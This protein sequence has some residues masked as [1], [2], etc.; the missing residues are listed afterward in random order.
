MTIWNKVYS[1]GLIKKSLDAMSDFY[2]VMAEDWYHSLIFSFFSTS[3]FKMNTVLYNYSIGSGVSTSNTRKLFD[4]ESIIDSTSE[5]IGHLKSFF[6]EHAP[7]FVSSCSIL[8]K[9]MLHQI[10]TAHIKSCRDTTDQNRALLYLVPK[11]DS[12]LL[13]PYLAEIRTKI[14]ELAALKKRRTFTQKI[15]GRIKRVF[16]NKSGM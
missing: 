13:L 3:Y 6:C 2:A 8:E 14:E 9:R 1:D 16:S 4:I 10:I 15:T 7:H 12:E 11:F 5:I